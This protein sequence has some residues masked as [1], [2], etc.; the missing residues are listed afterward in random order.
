M[1]NLRLDTVRLDV[2]Q[3][4]PYLVEAFVRWTTCAEAIEGLFTKFQEA[5]SF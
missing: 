5:S 1:E 4:L 3:P 2:K